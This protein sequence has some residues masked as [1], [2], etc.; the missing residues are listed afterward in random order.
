M[1]EIFAALLMLV[2]LLFSGCSDSGKYSRPSSLSSLGFSKVSFYGERYTDGNDYHRMG[3][4]LTDEAV[5]RE[6]WDIISEQEKCAEIEGTN[7]L[8]GTPRL[9][10]TDKYGRTYTVSYTWNTE[11]S[12]TDEFGEPYISPAGECFLIRG[13]KLTK[14]Y[15]VKDKSTQ[16]RF[17]ELI[18]EALGEAKP[19]DKVKGEDVIV[20]LN[21]YT[22]YAW[23]EDNE[24]S[25]VDNHGDIYCFDFAGKGIDSDDAFKDALWEVY[26]ESVPVRRGAADESELASILLDDIP[27]IN[28]NAK[29]TEEWTACDAGQTTLFAVSESGQLI[30]LR[31]EGDYTRQL[32]DDTAKRLCEYYDGL[33]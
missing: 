3:G 19:S 8:S 14:R 1:K 27:A 18:C 29:I 23:G 9:M 26:C 15:E 4:E 16:N 30:E 22:N 10:I 31:S 6:L 5:T 11:E 17:G 7:Y 13:D 32:E 24:G 28:R 21:H 25:F 33:F 2:Q 12:G 20:F